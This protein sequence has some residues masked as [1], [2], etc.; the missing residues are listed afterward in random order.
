MIHGRLCTG[1]AHKLFG[2]RACCHYGRHL[3]ILPFIE[4]NLFLIWVLGAE[5]IITRVLPVA[6]LRLACRQ[7]I[8]SLQ[9]FLINV[10]AV[11]VVILT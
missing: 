10:C 5:C 8:I 3:N 6:E 2:W 11:A 9:I 7:R 4:V 1:H